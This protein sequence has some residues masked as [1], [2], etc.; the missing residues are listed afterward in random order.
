MS[1][2][3]ADRTWFLD[4]GLIACGPDYIGETEGTGN[5]L[6]LMTERRSWSLTRPIPCLS[7]CLH[8]VWV[9]LLPSRL[10]ACRT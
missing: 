3:M 9:S 6:R 8:L 10:S 2:D 1:A 5:S 4:G 7:C